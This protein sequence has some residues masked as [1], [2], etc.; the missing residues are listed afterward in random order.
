M[1]D[2]IVIAIIAVAVA[3][4]ARSTIKHFKGEGGCCGGGSD[5][6]PRKKKL[7]NILYKKIFYVEGMHCDHC[8]NRVEETVNDFTGIA[9]I[10]DLKKGTLT[11]SYATDVDDDIIISRIERIGYSVAG[12][13]KMQ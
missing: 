11:I 13:E 12:I 4:G 1:S 3:A 5:Y 8:K 10:A 6:K 9:G 7:S 2:L